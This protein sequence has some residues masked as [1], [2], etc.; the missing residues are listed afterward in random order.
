[1]KKRTEKSQFRQFEQTDSELSGGKG[2]GENEEEFI[3]AIDSALAVTAASHLTE[4]CIT[5]PRI[6]RELQMASQ[7]H[8]NQ[9]PP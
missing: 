1:M 8:A 2:D 7:K 6:K 4:Q 9:V 5:R 3:D